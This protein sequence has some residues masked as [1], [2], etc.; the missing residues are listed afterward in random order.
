MAYKFESKIPA[1]MG[2]TMQ[3]ALYSWKDCNKNVK[4]PTKAKEYT[5]IFSFAWKLRGM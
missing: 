1:A 3:T 4:I 2:P 5:I